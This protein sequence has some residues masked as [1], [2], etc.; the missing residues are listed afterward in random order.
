M[1]CLYGLFSGLG[2]VLSLIG[3]RRR[4]LYFPLLFLVLGPVLM[5][6]RA[7]SAEPERANVVLVYVDDMGYGDATCYNPD[8]YVE[9]PAIDALA[10]GG[11]RFTNGYVTAPIWLGRR[12]R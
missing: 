4:S 10:E 3:L 8:A 2:A 7:L 12:R 11:V 1:N 9:T 6:R 5:L